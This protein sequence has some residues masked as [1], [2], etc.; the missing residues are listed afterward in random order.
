MDGDK[1]KSMQEKDGD[2][3][4][5][6]TGDGED[7]PTDDGDDSANKSDNKKIEGDDDHV[8]EDNNNNNDDTNENNKYEAPKQEVVPNPSRRWDA[9][10]TGKSTIRGKAEFR[11]HNGVIE[12]RSED[13]FSRRGSRLEM[14]HQGM[15][16]A[17]E[18]EMI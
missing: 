2:E 6:V 10:N 11:N 14:D 12:D 7:T 17:E 3:E 5:V 1:K 9:L 8:D 18:E 16:I 13:R 15:T 4:D